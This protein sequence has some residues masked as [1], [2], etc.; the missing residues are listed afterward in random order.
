LAAFDE[1]FNT[2][3]KEHDENHPVKKI[4]AP[5]PALGNGVASEK[6]IEASY[7]QH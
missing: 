2:R 3:F 7:Y 5:W 4:A 1:A 6:E